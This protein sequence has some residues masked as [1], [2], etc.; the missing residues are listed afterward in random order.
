M[1]TLAF[2]L[3]DAQ[4]R[5]SPGRNSKRRAAVAA[6]VQLL[7]RR[8][9]PHLLDV[10]LVFKPQIDGLDYLRDDAN[11]SLHSACELLGRFAQHKDTLL[12]Q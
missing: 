7:V 5:S 12:L 11:V 6:P 4:R 9:L 8:Q 1:M 10:H 2:A 3:H